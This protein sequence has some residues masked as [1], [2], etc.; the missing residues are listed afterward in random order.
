MIPQMGRQAARG[1][2]MLSVGSD[3]RPIGGF[4]LEYAE[5]EQ[6][7]LRR[8]QAVASRMRKLSNARVIPEAYTRLLNCSS[9]VDLTRSSPIARHWLVEA[10]A[11]RALD[12]WLV[13]EPF[14]Q[15][16]LPENDRG[17][18]SERM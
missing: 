7:P 6:P 3:I 4:R 15:W 2:H 1:E 8:Q 10:A 14:A 11:S 18:C 9:P 13:R 12:A 5:L 16:G 17:I